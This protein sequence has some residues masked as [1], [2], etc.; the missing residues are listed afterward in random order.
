MKKIAVSTL[1][2]AMFGGVNAA[3]ADVSV[4][5]L[6]TKNYVDEGLKAVNNKA[7]SALTLIGSEST[8]NSEGTG[9]LG[10]IEV[11]KND[12]NS[13]DTDYTN[14]TNVVGAD[15]EHGL[16]KEV[17]DNAEAIRA[18]QNADSSYNQGDGIVI[19]QQTR[20]ISIN[21]AA[22][23]EEGKQYVYKDGTLTELQIVSSWDDYGPD[24]D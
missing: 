19:D 12:I 10:D 3:F 21:G 1:V 17:A 8:A 18:L 11:I 9:I 23:A 13:L 2:L 7:K 20:T 5:S 6:T 24:L 16:R 15:A 4:N 14:L 22:E